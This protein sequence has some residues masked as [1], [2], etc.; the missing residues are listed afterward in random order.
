M[1]MQETTRHEPKVMRMLCEEKQIKL[2]FYKVLISLARQP[3]SQPERN[4][5]TGHVHRLGN[6]SALSVVVRW[7]PCMY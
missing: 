1:M 5:K 4:Q 2:F 7:Q 6:Q 3:A